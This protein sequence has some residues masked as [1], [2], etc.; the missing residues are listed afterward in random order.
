MEISKNGNGMEDGKSLRPE[1]CK[2]SL[3]VVYGDLKAC[4][5]CEVAYLYMEQL[6]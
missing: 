6:P 4:C 2:V 3:E 1:K 5:V